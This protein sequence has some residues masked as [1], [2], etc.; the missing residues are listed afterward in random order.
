MGDLLLKVEIAGAQNHWIGLGALD[1][2]EM[3]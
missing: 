3:S 1:W 2:G